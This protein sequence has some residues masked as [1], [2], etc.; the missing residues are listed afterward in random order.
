MRDLA[1]LA[2]AAFGRRGEGSGVVGVDV[3]R[4]RRTLGLQAQ[5]PRRAPTAR[6]AA[7]PR[8][9]PARFER[10][11][12]RELE[13]ALIERTEK[14]PPVAAARRAR[15]G[16]ADE[17]D[18]GPRRRPPRGRP[19]QAPAGDARPRAAR[20]HAAARDRRHAADDARLARDRRRAAAAHA[21]GRSARAGPRSTCSATSRPR[22]PRRASSSSRSCTRSTT[23]FAS[24]AA[25]SSSSGSP[26]SPRSSS[27]SATSARSR[28]QISREGGV[29]DVSGYTDYGRVWLE[30][31]ERDLRGPRPAL[32]RDRARRRAHQR[33]R[34]PRRGLR[35]DRRARRAHLLAQ[36]RAA[37]L[38]ELRRLGDGRLRA[39]LHDRASSAGRPSTSRTSSTWS[40]AAPRRWIR[41]R[42]RRRSAAE[43]SPRPATRR[44]GRRSRSAHPPSPRRASR[45]APRWCG[46]ATSWSPSCG[47]RRVPRTSAV[48]TITWP[49]M[50]SHSNVCTIRSGGV[51][52]R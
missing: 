45:R 44:A 27:A 32:D 46:T 5:R 6:P 14:L 48:S 11:L 19:A 1:R 31:L 25:S 28:E 15:P 9:D 8:A 17:P 35:P 24:C 43:L 30:F 16:A 3:Q 36:P 38:L 51:T 41:P 4:I 39:P 13:R 18:P 42:A 40:P 21:T 34:A 29:A 50:P 2:I 26:R 52:S 49:G 22:S 10:H 47:R 23:R 12:R 20:A 37:P 33:P 7:R